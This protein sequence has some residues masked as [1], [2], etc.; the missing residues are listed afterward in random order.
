[1]RK[2]IIILSVFLLIIIITILFY[3]LSKSLIINVD[4]LFNF[5]KSLGYPGAFIAGFLGSSSIFITIFP[6]YIIIALLGGF[7]SN[8]FGVFLIGIIAGLGAGVGQYFHYYLGVGGRYVLSEKRKKSL[9]VWRNRLEKY[10]LWLILLFAMT[11]LTPDDLVWIP[12]GLI[13]YPKKK[14]LI[15]AVTGKIVLNVF[16]ALAGFYGWP[17]IEEF[18]KNIFP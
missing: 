9:D 3:L 7:Q 2:C 13:C 12:L 11:P 17:L 16:Y 1:M 15:A 14:A 6:S 5:I 18:L 8:I 10:G 4:Q